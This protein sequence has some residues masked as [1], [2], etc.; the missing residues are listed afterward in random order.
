MIDQ[1]TDGLSRGL[2]LASL[3]GSN[4]LPRMR[5][6]V[7]LRGSQSHPPQFNG[8]SLVSASIPPSPS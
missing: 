4:D 6:A 5:C 8:S 1:R 2:R 3:D 7:Y